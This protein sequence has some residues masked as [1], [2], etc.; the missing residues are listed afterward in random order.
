MKHSRFNKT[1]IKRMMAH[2][3]ACLES[4]PNGVSN[5][6]LDG[7]TVD[8]TICIRWLRQEGHQIVEQRR[9]P[10]VVHYIKVGDSRAKQTPRENF[11]RALRPRQGVREGVSCDQ[12]DIR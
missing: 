2:V 12:T 8:Y 11:K 9:R 1:K 6:E 5:N 7:I 4:H 10:G 3:L